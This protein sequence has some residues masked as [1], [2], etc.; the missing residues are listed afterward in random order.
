MMDCKN[1]MAPNDEELLSYALDNEPLS[2]E[3]EEH[4]AHCPVCQ[5]RLK[6]YK[7][8]N[9]YLLANLYRTQCPGATKLNYY[10]ANLLPV[11]E[12]F[13]IDSHLR[14]CPLCANE[15]STIRQSLADIDLFPLFDEPPL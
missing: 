15:V 14:I 11:E 8:T 5:Q 3:M 7:Q 10:C 6:N 4:I 9:A 2:R 1:S 13:N 12:V